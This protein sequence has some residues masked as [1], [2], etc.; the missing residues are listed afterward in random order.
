MVV[1]QVP[2]PDCMVYGVWCTRVVM[3][4]DH[5]DLV[6]FPGGPYQVEPG[7]PGVDVA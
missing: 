1:R 7:G 4:E 2:R 6:R 5:V 3:L